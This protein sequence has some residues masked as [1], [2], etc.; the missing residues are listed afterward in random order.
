MGADDEPDK[1]TNRPCTAE[2]DSH[3]LGFYNFDF[4]TLRD[5]NRDIGTP[6]PD[7]RFSFKLWQH[8]TTLFQISQRFQKVRRVRQGWFA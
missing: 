5:V 7:N 1:V 2:T 8:A 6:M 3:S 4:L